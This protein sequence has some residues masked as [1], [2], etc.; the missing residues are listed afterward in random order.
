M[1][2]AKTKI[3]LDCRLAG[4]KNAGIGRYIENL[5]I[6]LPSTTS[7]DIELY[8]F[9]HDQKQLDLI[10]EKITQPKKVKFIFTPIR[11]YSFKEQTTWLK[12]VNQADLDLLHVPHFNI[13]LLYQGKLVVTIHDLLWHQQIGPEA[14]TLPAWKYYF[15]YLAYRLVTRQAV[16][17]AD[18]IV[19]PAKTI[20]QILT[21]HFKKIADKTTITKEGISRIFAQEYLQ[22]KNKQINADF[23]SRQLIY[24]GSLYPHKNVDLILRALKRLPEFNLKIVSARNIFVKRFAA[25]VKKM[26]LSSQVDFA[27]YLTDEQLV[28]ELKNSLA[29]IQPSLSEGFGLTGVEAMACGVPVLA[30]NIPIFE[31]VYQQAP[32]YFSP[33]DPNQLVAQIKKIK[34]KNAKKKAIKLGYETVANY[35]WSQ[36]TQKT[37]KIYQKALSK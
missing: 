36:M 19:V 14:T 33:F 25:K 12:V 18:Q 30:S 5:L 22:R 16:K 35:D 4:Q 13:P 6:W 17:K 3:G 37:W 10:K 34:T 26:G 11:H 21:Q 20:K 29:L 9:F 8:Y 27:G 23:Q 1:S 31:E 7:N 24:V 28:K 32:L 2:K 15:K